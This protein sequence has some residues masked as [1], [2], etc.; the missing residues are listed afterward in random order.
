MILWDKA[1]RLFLFAAVCGLVLTQCVG[2]LAGNSTQIGNGMVAGVIYERDGK[3]PAKGAQVSVRKK[4]APSSF[5]AGM[6][7]RFADTAAATTTDGRGVFMIDSIDTG[8][9]ILQAT[10][11]ANDFVMNDSVTVADPDSTVFLSDTLKPAGVIKGVVAL[12]E[13][14]DPRKVL[15]RVYPVAREAKVG[16]DGSFRFPDM[17]EGTYDLRV[18]STLD[19]YG[20]I[21][22]PGIRVKS[23]DTA[24][25]DTIELPFL[26]IPTL[27]NVAI[28][29]DTLKQ[30]VT[31]HWNK[32]EAEVVKSVNVYRRAVDPVTAIFTPINFHPILDTFF[33]DSLCDPNRTYEYRACAVDS[34]GDEGARSAGV[35]AHISLYDII[36][37][38][39]KVTYDTL[40]QRAASEVIMFIEGISTAARR[41]GLRST[42]SRLPIPYLS[43]QR[44]I[45]ARIM[46]PHPSRQRSRHTNTAS[47]P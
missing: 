23:S 37:A 45:S 10:D 33:V 39:F 29:Y 24:D 46:I 43:I 47:E 34:N 20:V 22:T 3:T 12:R 8:L 17:A 14:G 2:K 40:R 4:V 42:T 35:K 30:R 25:L 13:G 19:E 11:G 26:D 7:K 6:M 18:L 41:F 5:P 27:K 32:P 28:S 31:I 44:S 16:T 36:P 1:N 38:D 15:V 21:D 9:Y